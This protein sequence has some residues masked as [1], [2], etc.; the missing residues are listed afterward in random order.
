MRIPLFVILLFYSGFIKAQID[1]INLIRPVAVKAVTSDERSPFTY[2][3]LTQKDIDKR[4]TGQDLPFL[5]RLTPSVVVTSDA[6]NGIGYTGIRLRGTDASSINVTINGIPLNDAESQGMYW[7]NLP[8]LGASVSQ[9][10]IQRGVGTSTNGPGAF[11]GSI[12]LNTLGNVVKPGGK[13]V[14]SMGSFNSFR[15]SVTWNTGMIG[16]G[17]NVEGRISKIESDGYIDNAFSDLKSLYT[18]VAKRWDKGRFSVT[19]I[20]GTERTYQAWNGL[21]Q[22]I[23]NENV[24]NQEID[25]WA[26]NSGEYGY[27]EDVERLDDLKDKRRRHNYY[28]YKDQVDQYSQNHLQF[29]FEQYIGKA[30][31]GVSFYNTV[32][33]GYYEQYESDDAFTIYGLDAPMYPDSTYAESSN[34]IRRRWLDNTLNG[35]IVNLDLPLEKMDLQF[36]GAFSNYLCDHFGELIWMEYALDVVPG[37]RYYDNLGD[38]REGSA[39]VRGTFD[40]LDEKVQVQ[41]EIQA[42]SVIYST[43]G[44]DSDLSQISIDDTLSFINPKLGLDFLLND[45]SRTFAS[46]AIANREPSRS[47]YIDS[48]NPNLVQSERLIDFEFGY[49]Y[50]ANKWATEIGLYHMK[51]EDQLIATG[52]LNDVGTPIRINVPNSYR[53]GIEL[54][55]GVELTPRFTF[56][57]NLT[58]SKNKIDLFEEK[59]Y[60]SITEPATVNTINHVNSDIAFSPNVIGSGVLTFDAW[61]NKNNKI[62]LEL[63]T[64]YVGAQFMDNTSNYDRS[65]PAYLVNDLSINWFHDKNNEGISFSLFFKNILN[66]MY[67]ANGYTYSYLYGGMDT[68][69]TEN[70]VYPQAGRHQFINVAYHF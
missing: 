67:S 15:S 34:V 2:T 11:G 3:D 68:M 48:S 39:Y 65:L 49:K 54:Q 52:A 31:L 45:H 1:S 58:V 40:L 61:S 47:D 66:E 41:T 51:Y 12:A 62:S 6:G 24:T 37:T 9:L 22:F 13:V 70:Y 63:I 46:V 60:D 5:L 35:G 32:G 44:I 8:D 25:D 20:R 17:W 57:A 28:N 56:D 26:V 36:G 4:D 38:K 33:G 7:V 53:Q 55:V 50:S 27:G 23:T 69:V 59:L 30:N 21:P 19:S 43:F 10:Q 14:L 29:H 64:K 42:R 16:N 18:S